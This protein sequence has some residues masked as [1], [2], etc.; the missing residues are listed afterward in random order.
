MRDLAL[1]RRLGELDAEVVDTAIPALSRDAAHD[2][3]AAFNLRDGRDP[4]VLEEL[5][6]SVL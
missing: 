1:P 3:G 2:V 6:R 5:Y 4:L